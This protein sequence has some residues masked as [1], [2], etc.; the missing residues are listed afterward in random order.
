MLG[1]FIGRELRQRYVGSV[2]GRAWPFLQPL[3]ILGVYW[4]VFFQ[5]LQVRLGNPAFA[6]P[7]N[8]AYGKD[9]TD[10]FYVLLLCGG[11]VPWL[12]TAEF[13][14]RCT[15][16]VVENGP[17]VKKIAFPTELLPIYLLGAY[18]VNLLIMMGFFLGFA[19]IFTPFRSSLIWMLPLVMAVH[20]ILLL[21]LGYIC[22]TIN[23]FVR[24]VSQLMPLIVNMWF[25]LTPVV[26]PREMLP[27]GAKDWAW[28]FDWNPMSR[29][30]QVYRW[31][32]V[33]PED[34]RRTVDAAGNVVVVDA[35][36][37]WQN[38]GI[39]AAIATGFFIAGYSLFMSQKHKFADEI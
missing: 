26:Y 21:G 9:A 24:D 8:D 36:L 14:M 30:V 38:L 12:I 31:V 28:I 15:N 16:T 13:V 19:W 5:I 7:I 35:T 4:L 3:L 1:A 11:L 17:L 27:D 39:V 23:V 25:F 37:V 6:Q 18:F 10:T 32:T 22:A 34:I 20:G 33:F 2:L 29:L